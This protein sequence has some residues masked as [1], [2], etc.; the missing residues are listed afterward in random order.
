MSNCRSN[1]I[2][3]NLIFRKNFKDSAVILDWEYGCCMTLRIRSNLVRP[4][5][6][7][8]LL[9]K[10]TAIHSDVHTQSERNGVRGAGW[11]PNTDKQ[12]ML[13]FFVNYADRWNPLKINCTGCIFFHKKTP[14]KQQKTEKPRFVHSQHHNIF[15]HPHA[16]NMAFPAGKKLL[17][18]FSTG[19]TNR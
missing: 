18:F 10:E 7:V 19:K 9:D 15:P 14:T 16:F 12:S 1:T 5:Q 11:K 17:L 13:T 4:G 2:T 8:I 6:N 3:E